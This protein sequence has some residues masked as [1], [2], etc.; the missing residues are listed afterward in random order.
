MD[1]GNLTRGSKD[2]P[3][4]I[5]TTAPPSI[6]RAS[7][8]TSRS[9]IAG[10]GMRGHGFGLGKAL[11]RLLLRLGYGPTPRPQPRRTHTEVVT[12]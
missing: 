1:T 11:A 8:R 4:S 12:R 6:A 3:T 5:P 2:R 7:Q 9:D 10:V